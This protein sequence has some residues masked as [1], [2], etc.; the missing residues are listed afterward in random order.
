[1]KMMDMRQA[2]NRFGIEVKK[3]CA[4]CA[5]KSIINDVAL[6]RCNLHRHKVR[7][8]NC[9]RAWRMSEGLRHA[10]EK[11][12]PQP[13]PRREGRRNHNNDTDIKAS[14]M[15]GGLAGALISLPTGEGRGEAFFN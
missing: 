4:S 2:V 1:M 10:G 6:R 11:P 12:L 8:H 5:F 3:C 9:C 14:P 13:L 7:P 15:G